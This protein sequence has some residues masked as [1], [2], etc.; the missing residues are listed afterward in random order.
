MPVILDLRGVERPLRRL[1]R[2]PADKDTDPR[3]AARLDRVDHARCVEEVSGRGGDVDSHRSRT[4]GRSKR[5]R[6]RA[7]GAADQESNPARAPRSSGAATRRGVP[8]RRRTFFHQ[9]PAPM[10]IPASRRSRTQLPGTGMPGRPVFDDVQTRRQT[11]H[12]RIGPSLSLKPAGL[13]DGL[14]LKEQRYRGISARFAPTTWVPGSPA[15]S[16]GFG[17]RGQPS[18]GSRPLRQQHREIHAKC[19]RRSAFA[20]ASAGSGRSCPH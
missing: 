2:V 16:Q 6:C 12:I 7:H 13:A 3:R 11:P 18:T 19:D 17:M 14:A 8:R 5:E 20:S 9:R 4:R 15:S 10:A 1:D